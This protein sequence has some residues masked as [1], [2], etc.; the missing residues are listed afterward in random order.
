MFLHLSVILFTG[1]RGVHPPRQT[2]PWADTLP[3]R[4]PSR[5]D[6]PLDRQP[7]LRDGDSSGRYWNAFLLFKMIVFCEIQLYF[8]IGVPV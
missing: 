2:P 6:T 7:P 1:V 3:G 8:G 5:A 4:P